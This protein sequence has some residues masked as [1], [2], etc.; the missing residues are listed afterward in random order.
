MQDYE[1]ASGR[2]QDMKNASPLQQ[3][4]AFVIQGLAEESEAHFKS[5]LA[6]ECP[7]W[8]SFSGKLH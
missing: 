4:T 2:L 6:V 1:H 7:Q 8:L 3:R 5:H